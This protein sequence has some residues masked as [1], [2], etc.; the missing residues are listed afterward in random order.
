MDITITFNHALN[1]S[2]Q[3]GDS[4]YYCP[5]QSLGGFDTVDN[6]NLPFTGIVRIGNCTLINQ[7][8]NTITILVDATIPLSAQQS[9]ANGI[10]IGDFVMFSKNTEVNLSSLLGYYAEVT[11]SNN[12]PDK[13][14]L[15]AVSTEFSES[16]K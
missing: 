6:I 7:D 3:E 13:S 2:L 14:E 4:V 15:F 9:I 11:F 1:D 16:S 12:S 5:N 10:G 8:T